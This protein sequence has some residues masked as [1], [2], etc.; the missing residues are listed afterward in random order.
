MSG[1]ESAIWRAASRQSCD[2]ASPYGW[3]VAPQVASPDTC[4]VCGNGVARAATDSNGGVG[5]PAAHRPMRAQQDRRT[6]NGPRWP[7]GAAVGALSVRD[8]PLRCG[9]LVGP[10][11]G[12]PRLGIRVGPL[13]G[14]HVPGEPRRSLVNSGRS[15]LGRE[16]QLYTSADWVFTYRISMVRR[17]VPSSGTSRLQAPLAATDAELWL[18]TSEGSSTASPYLQVASRLLGAA[19]TTHATA[20][21]MPRPYLC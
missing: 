2:A 10:I 21:P 3:V 7:V 18:Q 16:V 4:T 12:Q 13:A 15:L 8:L 20:N 5:Q 6:G 1:R 14:G 19:P 9:D 17:H 11:Q